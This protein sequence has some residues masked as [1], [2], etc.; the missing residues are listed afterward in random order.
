M[1][2]QHNSVFDGDDLTDFVFQLLYITDAIP[3]MP[4]LIYDARDEDYDVLGTCPNSDPRG[5]SGGQ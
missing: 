5:R 3:L 2:T 1:R 4:K